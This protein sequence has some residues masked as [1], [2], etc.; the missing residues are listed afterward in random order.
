MTIYYNSL[1]QNGRLGN[2]M[3]QYASL[4]G[5][6]RRH[7]YGYSIPPST[8]S[9]THEL[10]KTFRLGQDVNYG[11]AQVPTIDEKSFN[12]D[13]NLFENCPDNININGYFQSY[14]YFDHIK[15]EIVKDFTL[16]KQYESLNGSYCSVHIRRTDY[17]GF[18]NHHPVCDLDYYKTA[19]DMIGKQTTFVVVSDDIEWCQ[20]N[21]RADAYS[22][23][24]DRNKDLHIMMNAS[25]NIIANSSFSWWGAWLN[26]NP[27]KIV[28]CPKN[29]FGPAY[30]HY[31][32]RDLRPED[33]IQI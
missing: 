28:V 9:D 14:K 21:I 22:D 1:G 6:A 10:R 5:I 13:Y 24:S 17:L 23:S 4:K 31:D 7:G 26:Q 15:D 18:P 2:Q 32:M 30:K 11:V 3:F 8:V 16:K 25:Y 12:F 19:M 33:W 29:W 20:N 27:N